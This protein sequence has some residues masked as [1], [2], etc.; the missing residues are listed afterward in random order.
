MKESNLPLAN[1]ELLA[2]DV[3]ELMVGKAVTDR[4][5]LAVVLVHNLQP[6]L[7]VQ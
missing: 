2:R 3:L 7:K 1:T 4:N 6:E 5:D